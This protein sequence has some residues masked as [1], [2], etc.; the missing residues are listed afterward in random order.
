MWV[1]IML[2]SGSSGK[3]K[4]E[5]SLFFIFFIVSICILI[6]SFIISRYQKESYRSEQKEFLLNGSILESKEITYW[7]NEKISEARSIINNSNLIDE[8]KKLAKKP[9]NHLQVKKIGGFI[10]D[11]IAKKGYNC[12][13]LLDSN[14]K[15]L[16]NSGKNNI[17]SDEL[18]LLKM[19][20]SNKGIIVTDPQYSVNDK[21]NYIYLLVPLITESKKKSSNPESII[22]CQIDFD[23]LLKSQKISQQIQGLK[24]ESF[25]LKKNADSLIC[26]SKLYSEEN[27]VSKHQLLTLLKELS[28][29]D[30]LDNTSAVKKE[31]ANDGRELIH[32]CQ[33]IAGTP[34]YLLTVADTE[35]SL[36]SFKISFIY[37]NFLT[38]LS[39]ITSGAGLGYYWKIRVKI[40]E[41]QK[42]Q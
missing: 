2:G 41:Q 40:Q 9:D 3:N 5:W 16:Y 10:E 13:L 20:S 18:C 15:P 4:I 30:L 42:T 22:L 17:S 29:N 24:N 32:Y 6:S 39:L 35:E 19:Q 12:I 28:C 7:Y 8:I 1:N 21:K 31:I 38:L 27:K 34:W 37:I 33:S 36:A 25:L 23:L 14:Y 26:L 11:I